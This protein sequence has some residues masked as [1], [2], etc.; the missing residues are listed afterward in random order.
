MLSSSNSSGITLVYLNTRVHV[1]NKLY[2]TQDQNPQINLL[3]KSDN[4]CIN[5]VTINI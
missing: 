5:I 4:V 2:H 1:T 3:Y